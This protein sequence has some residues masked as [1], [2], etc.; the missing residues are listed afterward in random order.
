MRKR[1]LYNGFVVLILFFLVACSDRPQ[2]KYLT[3][4]AVVLAFGDSLTWGT[5]GGENGSYPYQLEQ[6]IERQVINAGV[7][8]ETSA[9]GVKRLPGLLEEYQP[10]LLILCHGGNDLLRRLD[11]RQ[12]RDNLRQ[13]IELAQQSGTEVVIIGVPNPGLMI[14]PPDFYAE[15]AE[16]FKLPFLSEALAE[17][18][19]ERKFKSDTVH[20]NA[21]GYRQLAQR[22]KELLKAAKAI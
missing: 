12:L 21:A 16:E 20:L 10:Q 19:S 3:A 15:L 18:E 11:R 5:G 17:L 8:G 1:F 9:D 13:M 7:P 4:E 6:L 22:V 2:L 14:G